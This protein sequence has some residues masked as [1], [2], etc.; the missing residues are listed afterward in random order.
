MKN[1]EVVYVKRQQNTRN[2]TQICISVTGGA[3]GGSEWVLA[4]PLAQLGRIPLQGM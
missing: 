3:R 1:F 4:H 2:G